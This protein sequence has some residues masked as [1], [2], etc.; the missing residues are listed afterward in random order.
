MLWN[1]YSLQATPTPEPKP[2]G[3][4]LAIAIR[5]PNPSRGGALWI[6]VQ[7]P[8]RAPAT[9]EL[10]DLQ[11]RRVFQREVGALGPGAHELELGHGP[12]G[13]GLYL[14]RIQQGAETRT[15][16]WTVLR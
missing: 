7:L 3:M 15:A 6:N 14:A 5:G 10:L 4:A 12:W 16:R 2:A 8:I 1:V 13:A 9:L 11:G